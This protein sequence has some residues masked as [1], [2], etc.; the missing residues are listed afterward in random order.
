[1]ITDQKE[2]IPSLLEAH[3]IW[4]VA[5]ARASHNELLSGLMIA[6][7]RWIHVATRGASVVAGEV[8]STPYEQITQAIQSQDADDAFA[9]MK[10]HVTKRAK[11][12]TRLAAQVEKADVS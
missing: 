1:L 3:S 7:V 2:D 5:V 6:L 8:S 11:V 10:K 12:M 9:R 4:H